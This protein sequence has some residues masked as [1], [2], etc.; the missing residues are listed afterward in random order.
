MAASL[1]V[2]EMSCELLDAIGIWGDHSLDEGILL[3]FGVSDGVWTWP[4]GGQP[5]SCN[6]SE[7]LNHASTKHIFAEKHLNY[8]VIPLSN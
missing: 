2:T 4:T 6:E 1:Q 7:E 8:V 3:G 5:N